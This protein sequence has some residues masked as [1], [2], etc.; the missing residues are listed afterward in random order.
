[1]EVG[2]MDRS[3]LSDEQWERIAPLLPG[4]IGDPGGSGRDNRQFLEA[5]LWIDR[6]GAPWRDFPSAFGRW[7]LVCQR[8]RRWSGKGV[9]WLLLQALSSEGTVSEVRMDGT[10][11]RVHRHGAGALKKRTTIDRPV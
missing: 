4:K 2:F 11:V 7:N 5:V 6:T 9:F 8:F 10:H 1:M 3:M